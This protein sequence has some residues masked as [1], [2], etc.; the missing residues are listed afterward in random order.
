MKDV[1]EKF[2]DRYQSQLEPSKKQQGRT[3]RFLTPEPDRRTESEVTNESDH[4]LD[5]EQNEAGDF[6]PHY[7]PIEDSTYDSSLFDNTE[8]IL[9]TVMA[10][11][12]KNRGVER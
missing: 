5:K 6:N 12:L 11:I 4:L 7:V 2:R 9:E 10:K 1:K 3:V 8:Y